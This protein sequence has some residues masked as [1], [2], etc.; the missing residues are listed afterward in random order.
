MNKDNKIPAELKAQRKWVCVWNN[1]KIP[2]RGFERRAASAS[3]PDTWCDFETACEA[4]EAGIYDG[5]GYV[6]D[7]DGYIGIDIDT[8]FDNHGFLTQATADIIQHCGSYTEKSRSG[9]GVHIILKGELPFKGKNN[10]GV[11]IYQTGRYFIMTGRQMFYDTIIENQQAIDY[12]VDKYFPEMLKTGEGCGQRIYEGRFKAP[13]DTH[14]SFAITYP[15]IGEGMRNISMASW[16]GQLHT[17]GCD[18]SEI[19]DELLKINDTA[20]DSPLPRHEVMAILNSIT[21]Y[22]RKDG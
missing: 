6:F 8:G 12:V 9:R 20:C 7:G 14:S 13:T 5:I 10:N 19:L 1:S 16:A 17:Y 18:K 11:E 4:V 22:R 15:P 21:K 2:M 3:N